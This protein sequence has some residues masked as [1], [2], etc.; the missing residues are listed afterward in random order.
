MIKELDTCISAKK[1]KKNRQTISKQKEQNSKIQSVNFYPIFGGECRLRSAY[2]YVQTDLILH[3]PLLYH[4]Y[5]S[6]EAYEIPVN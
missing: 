1:G 6:N 3:C 2:T 4:L 5:L